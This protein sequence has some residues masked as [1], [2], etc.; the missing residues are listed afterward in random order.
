MVQRIRLPLVASIWIISSVFGLTRAY[1]ETSPG[2]KPVVSDAKAVEGGS[3]KVMAKGT[4]AKDSLKPEFIKFR[5]DALDRISEL[6]ILGLTKAQIAKS[7]DYGVKR[8]VLGAPATG[9]A[10][11]GPT[12]KDNTLE[13]AT[14]LTKFAERDWRSK[15]SEG[16]PETRVLY[17]ADAQ[18]R[19]HAAALN[20]EWWIGEE[21]QYGESYLRLSLDQ[22]W[23]DEGKGNV[24][25]FPITG[26]SRE[27]TFSQPT[28]ANSPVEK[29]KPVKPAKKK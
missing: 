24:K 26:V 17:W 29:G 3:T 2:A 14:A 22:L 4:A 23:L 25:S 6:L 19:Q 7:E 10:Q 15:A 16:L 5:N 21:A 28:A 27:I 18:H 20:V 11:S 9:S 12:V 13:F 1:G 8:E